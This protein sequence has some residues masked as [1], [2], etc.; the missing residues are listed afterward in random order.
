[1]HCVQQDATRKSWLAGYALQSEIA[2][3]GACA[4]ARENG[5]VVSQE[6]GW[7]CSKG[8]S[9]CLACDLLESADVCIGMAAHYGSCV[10]LKH[11]DVQPIWEC[12]LR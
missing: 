3:S 1:M 5:E 4:K 9:T 8:V 12:E 11:N 6:E 10:A 2:F 7:Q